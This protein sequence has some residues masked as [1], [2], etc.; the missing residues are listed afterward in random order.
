MTIAEGATATLAWYDPRL[1]VTSDGVRRRR[2]R[3]LQSWYRETQ[4]GV[5]PGQHDRHPQLVGS[6]LPKE[7]A[8]DG[9]NFLHPQ[10]ASYVE[11]RIR[12]V[13]KANG[14]LDEDRLRRNMLSS[15][16]L[17][18]NLFGAF[19]AKRPAAARV[20]SA[21]LRLDIDTIDQVMVEHAP[22]ASKAVLGDRTAF[23]AFLA[24]TT[25]TGSKG[26]LG[27][28]TK[29]TEPFSPKAHRPA[30]YEANPAYH[31]A[32][33]RP[34]AGH[35]LGRRATNQLWRNTL[36]AAATR[37]SDRYA[38]GHA[39]VIAGRDDTAAWKAVAAVR[40]E[41]ENPNAMLRSVSLE[42]LVEQCQL[43]RSLADWATRFRRRYLDLSPIA[44]HFPVPTIPED[45][46]MAPLDVV[47]LP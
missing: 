27:V 37:R 17:C 4:L 45:Q 41:L 46:P 19:R 6:M 5:E 7:R 1:Q 31:W 24:Y 30:Y 8:L 32:G 34:G 42:R 18:F 25:S 44:P 12:E 29:Y 39:L 21:V 16:P 14:T 3:A 47:S 22:P 11:Q 9:L 28:E 26:F 36:L 40:T 35:R 2:F 23:D 43:Q 15:M 20:L 33:F 13:R 38:S 10:I